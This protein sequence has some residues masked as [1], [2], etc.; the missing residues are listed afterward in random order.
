MKNNLMHIPLRILG[1]SVALDLGSG[2]GVRFGGQEGG[3]PEMP[4]LIFIYLFNDSGA[5]IRTFQ[6]SPSMT[7]LRLCYME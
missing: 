4:N 7:L 6:L 3:L 1:E 2:S 5:D